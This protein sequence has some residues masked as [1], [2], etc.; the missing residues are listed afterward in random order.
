MDGDV[1]GLEA[2][3]DLL[4]RG[5]VEFGDGCWGYRCSQWRRTREGDAHLV[6]LRVD[7]GDRG[8]PHVPGTA[9]GPIPVQ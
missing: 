4:A 2:R 1:R 7:S 5:D 8:V 3:P 9:L 6:V